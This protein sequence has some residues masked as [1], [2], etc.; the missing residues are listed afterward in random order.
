MTLPKSITEPNLLVGPFT[1][2]KVVVDGREIPG[3]TGFPDNGK[4]ALVVDGR[5][6]ATFDNDTARQVAW[7]LAE[8]IAIERGYSNAGAKNKEM[9]FAPMCMDL[10]ALADPDELLGA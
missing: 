4:T 10:S 7:L 8:A 2:Y 5:F 6:T 3:L 1:V 9:P